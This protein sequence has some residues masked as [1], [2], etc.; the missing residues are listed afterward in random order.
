M[1][2]VL[3]FGCLFGAGGFLLSSGIHW[4]KDRKRKASEAERDEQTIQLLRDLQ[5]QAA[6][7]QELISECSDTLKLLPPSINRKKHPPQL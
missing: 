7:Q 1:T 6:E 5:T 4:Q 3:I 2:R